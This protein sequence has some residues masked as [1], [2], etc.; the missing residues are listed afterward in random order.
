MVFSVD[1]YI[2]VGRE[3]VKRSHHHGACEGT[4][5][6]RSLTDVRA[7]EFRVM[8]EAIITPLMALRREFTRI[9]LPRGFEMQTSINFL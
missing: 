4:G 8:T 6:I 1:D 2:N 3:A 5:L 7:E 9:V